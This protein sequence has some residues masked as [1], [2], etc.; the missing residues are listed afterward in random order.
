MLSDIE[1]SVICITYNHAKY[2]RKSLDSLV[3]QQCSVSYEII[4][5][6]DASTDDTQK[7]ITEYRDKYPELLI[8]ILQ[9]ENQMS[10]GVDVLVEPYKK[11]RGK[12]IAICEGDD[13]WNSPYK[14]QKQ[15]DAMKAHPECC[16]ATNRVICC[17]ED[18]SPDD[19]VFPSPS[20]QLTTGKVSENTMASLLW[21]K[22]GYPFHTCSYFFTRKCLETAFTL[23]NELPSIT[24]DQLYM[25]STL[26]TGPIWFID[27]PL[28][29]RRRFPIGGW[30]ARQTAGGREKDF[31]LA[32]RMHRADLRLNKLTKEVYHQMIIPHIY[33]N[34]MGFAP[35]YPF[36]VKQFLHEN[37][38][39]FRQCKKTYTLKNRLS[40]LLKSTLLSIC[41]TLLRTLYKNR[42]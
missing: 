22:D 21:G 30:S 11:C 27:E 2:L 41:P 29:V 18:G 9:K 12:Y 3:N 28:S 23:Y 4:V 14:L 40:L 8:P 6:D 32:L 19:R 31:D 13:Y 20:M 42:K 33:D 38:I 10:K 25:R 5:H 35:F 39:S 17:K 16:F 34:M 15:Y 36:E 7:I 26:L 37:N 24:G 1:I